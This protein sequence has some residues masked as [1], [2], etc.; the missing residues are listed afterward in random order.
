MTPADKTSSTEQ[1]VS[2][3]SYIS[4]LRLRRGE[5]WNA[6]DW[7]WGCMEACAEVDKLREELRKVIDVKEPK[8]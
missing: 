1:S 3:G 7:K 8:S 5:G 6:K 2:T 4:E